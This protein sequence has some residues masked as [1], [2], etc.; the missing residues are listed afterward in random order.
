MPP[1]FASTE[2]GFRHRKVPRGRRCGGFGQNRRRDSP[3]QPEKSHCLRWYWRRAAGSAVATKV[4]LH[5]R[6][7]LRC[8]RKPAWPRLVHILSRGHSDR[9]WPLRCDLSN[10]A[11]MAT[12]RYRSRSHGRWT[13]CFGWSD[14]SRRSG[15]RHAPRGSLAAWA[16]AAS[17]PCISALALAICPMFPVVMASRVLHAAASTMLLVVAAMSLALVGHAALGA[18]LGR[19]AR[20]ASLGNGIA[21]AAMGLCGYLASSQAVFFLTAALAAPAGAGAYPHSCECLAAQGRSPQARI[22]AWSLPS[23]TAACSFAL[24]ILIFQLANSAMLP[25]MGGILTMRSSAWASSL[26]AACIV[27]P[28]L[29]VA[30]CAPAIGRRAN[31]AEAA[32]VGLLWSFLRAAAFSFAFVDDPVPY[33]GCAGAGWESRLPVSVCA[34]PRGG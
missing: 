10:G 3:A 16:V 11:S 32:V 34:P 12:V 23:A 17:H 31:F 18:R 14:A 24:C 28:Q 29:I 21:A 9:V 1:R 13:G 7:H 22:R 5:R 26:I 19:N 33:C 6:R 2:T 8:R 27:L 20:F 15:L 30:G 25:L 4:P